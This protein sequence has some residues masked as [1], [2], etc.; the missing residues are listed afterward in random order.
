MAVVVVLP[1]V[2]VTASH[3]FTG[4]YRLEASKRH[5]SSTSPHSGNPAACAASLAALLKDKGRK[6]SRFAV[7][8]SG[9]NI[10]RELYL[11]ALGGAPL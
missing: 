3:F 4:P 7:I 5:A 11:D 2:P 1:L 8:L 10:D 9:G 6:G